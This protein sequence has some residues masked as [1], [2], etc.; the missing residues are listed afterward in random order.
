MSDATPPA[1]FSRVRQVDRRVRPPR[2][3]GNR[4]PIVPPNFADVI[5]HRRRVK[6]SSYYFTSGH[7]HL[8]NSR[9]VLEERSPFVAIPKTHLFGYLQSSKAWKAK[10]NHEAKSRKIED[11]HSYQSLQFKDLLRRLHVDVPIEIEEAKAHKDSDKAA[12]MTDVDPQYFTE[13]RGRVLKDR[14]SLKTY[15]NDTREVFKTR[16]L[17]GQERDDCIRIDQQFHEEQKRLDNIKRKYR[18]YVAGFEEFLSRDHEESM[19]VLRKAEDAGK[20]TNEL[21]NHLRDLSKSVGHIRLQVYVLEEAWRMVKTCQRFL[22]HVAPHS[23]RSKHDPTYKKESGKDEVFSRYGNTEEVA[24]LDSLIEMFEQDIKDASDP[25]MYFDDPYDLIHI[26]RAMELQNLNAMIHCESLAAPLVEMAASVVKTDVAIKGEIAEIF[27]GIQDLELAIHWEE[28]RAKSLEDY[29][30]YLLQGLFRELVCSETVL[31]L[32]V[33]VE[34]TYENCVAQNDANLDSYSMMKSIERVLE[35][36]NAQL[37]NLP[38]EVVLQCEKQGFRQEMKAMK[39]AED[40]ARKMA[41]MRR[42]L[43]ALVR[44][45]EPPITR[46]RKLMY[47]SAPVEVKKK[48]TPPPTPPSNEELVWLTYFT[49]YCERDDHHD[50]R[51]QYPDDFDLTFKPRGQRGV[52]KHEVK[53]EDEEE[54]ESENDDE[55]DD[56]EQDGVK[57]GNELNGKE[58]DHDDT[59]DEFRDEGT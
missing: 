59:E 25:E 39:D 48:V 34:D 35:E 26:F 15:V 12:A 43:A 29:A 53:V 1:S 16:L 52:A 37:D 31:H 4:Q 8:G 36:L 18:Q 42:L 23:W 57:N 38:V 40:A 10:G 49:N 55:E 6:R 11:A 46:Q 33:F 24:S 19:E 20:V 17:A 30:N 14:S 47:R 56:E 9:N 32:F 2:R 28:S 7:E 5:F 50:F 21:T 22:Y 45:M 3:R 44:I 13:L 51:S 58:E 41:L 27:E 54:D